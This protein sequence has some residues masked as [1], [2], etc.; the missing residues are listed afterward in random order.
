MVSLFEDIGFMAKRAAVFITG[1]GITMS[2][3]ALAAPLVQGAHAPMVAVALAAGVPITAAMSTMVHHHHETAIMNNFREEIAAQFQIDPKEVTHDHLRT[4]AFGDKAQGIQP[5][6]FFQQILQKNDRNRWI[7]IGA[8]MVSAL[9]TI[10]FVL[11]NGTAVSGAIAGAAATAGIAGGAAI[12]AVGLSLVVGAMMFAS[13]HLLE[14]VGNDVFSEKRRTAYEKLQAMA[15]QKQNGLEITPEQILSIA[16]SV[17][18]QVRQDML[19]DYGVNAHFS[20]LPMEEKQALLRK[21]DAALHITE[22]AQKINAGVMKIN[23]LAFTVVEERSGVPEV[24][25]RVAAQRSAEKP[26]HGIGHQISRARDWVKDALNERYAPA[27]V[28]RSHPAAAVVSSAPKPPNKIIETVVETVYPG[29]TAPVKGDM[30]YTV[31]FLAQ[32]ADAEAQRKAQTHAER[33][34][35]AREAEAQAQQEPRTVH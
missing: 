21:Y 10:G 23:E 28:L 14:M 12:G 9:G 7:D 34:L 16:S 3:V 26:H 33:L 17:H 35:I 18:P 13:T 15:R 4:L 20:T 31:S 29:S 27:H 25:P 30:P 32:Y 1:R 6:P 24:D 2:A 8:K 11:L 5:Q 19:N 22:S